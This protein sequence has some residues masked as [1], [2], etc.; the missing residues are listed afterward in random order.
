MKKRSL[1]VLLVI[2]S[3]IFSAV[4]QT[5]QT[6]ALTTPATTP[7][8]ATPATTPPTA[9]TSKL[10]SVNAS[11]A[12][13]NYSPTGYYIIAWN[14]TVQECDPVGVVD[15]AKKGTAI[16]KQ[17]YRFHV[18]G[19]NSKGDAI[20]QFRDLKPKHDSTA[21]KTFNG[22]YFLISKNDMTNNVRDYFDVNTIQFT[23]GVLSMPFKFRPTKSIVTNNLSLG[24]SVYGQFPGY[25]AWGYGGVLGLSLSSV[26]LDSLSTSG[27]V[28]TNTDRP[29]FTP[30]LSFVASHGNLSLI[31]GAGVDIINKT[32][33]IEKSWI[34]N[35][36]PWIGFGIGI[37][38]FTVSN[39]NT[40]KVSD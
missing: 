18:K 19:Y 11:S 23:Y 22:K 12:S 9:L 37:N 13:H 27:K 4:A 38:L 28:K 15:T 10:D 29:A 7:A 26:T 32:S 20:V 5:T 21:M 34:F 36:K 40:V 25:G 17:G 24:S 6:P 35:G 8:P 31:F 1:F 33:E 2:A 3:S 14:I 30:S 16:A 39:T